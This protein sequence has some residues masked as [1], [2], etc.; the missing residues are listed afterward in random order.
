MKTAA[1]KSRLLGRTPPPALTPSQPF[2]AATAAEIEF[3][4]ASDLVKIGLH[5]L[6]DDLPRAHTLSQALEGDASADYWHAII[7]RREGDFSNAKY[8]LRRMGPHPVLV[9]VH[10]DPDGA[11]LYVDRCQAAGDD[12]VE[13]REL[14]M[15]EIA[16]LLEFVERESGGIRAL[17][18]QL[19]RRRAVEHPNHFAVWRRNPCRRMGLHGRLTLQNRL[20]R[21]GLARACNQK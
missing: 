4:P 11:A 9:T 6:N 12:D 5:L 10:G 15:R 21:I 19:P 14:Q 17:P 20:R 13:L 3:L 8:W 18:L 7:H 1:L 16:A 2:D